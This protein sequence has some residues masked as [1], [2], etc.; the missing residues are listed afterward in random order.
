MSLTQWDYCHS[1]GY[2][3]NGDGDG[4]RRKRVSGRSESNWHYH[5][6]VVSYSDR[7]RR[8]HFLY[9][10]RKGLAYYQEYIRDKSVQLRI[11]ACITTF[12]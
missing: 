4:R 1:S 9:K 7:F 11:L 10:A 5:G 2:Q 8:L 12:F 3:G 6:R